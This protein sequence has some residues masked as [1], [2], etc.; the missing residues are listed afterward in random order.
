LVPSKNERPIDRLLSGDRRDYIGPCILAEIGGN[1]VKISALIFTLPQEGM[2]AACAPGAAATLP[3]ELA[4][5]ASPQPLISAA[6]PGDLAKAP[7]TPGHAVTA[8]LHPTPKIAFLTQPEKP[9]SAAAQGGLFQVQ[10]TQAATYR[11]AIG[12]GA[13]IDVLKDRAPVMSS[14][15]AH[16]PAC[17]GVGKMVD[18]PL[19]PGAY[20]VQI[21]GN[22]GPTL[23]LLLARLPR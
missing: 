1:A 8:T 2:S 6:N 12:S 4:P 19:Q 14:A 11:L 17:S 16:G 10:I 9:V 15:H 13:W 7:L 21:S 22:P 18:F 23:T 5:W 20:V 3:L